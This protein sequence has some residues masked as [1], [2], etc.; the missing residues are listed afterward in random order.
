MADSDRHEWV[1]VREAAELLGRSQRTIWR[2]VADGRLTANRDASP[3]K[4][5]IWRELQDKPSQLPRDT[6]GSLKAEVIRL[7][8][9]VD[10][11]ATLNDMLR[12]ERDDWHNAHIASLTNTQTLLEA[13]TPRRRFRWPWQR[14]N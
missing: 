6:V 8:A 13:G 10:K 2:Y 12:Q 7:T 1:T 4:V 9:E 3:V 14:G 11:L 5:D